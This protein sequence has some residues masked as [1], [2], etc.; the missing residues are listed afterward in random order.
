MAQPPD[1]EP[2]LSRWSKRK[3][4]E[5]RDPKPGTTPDDEALPEDDDSISRE[6]LAALPAIEDLTARTDIRP[7]LRKG[8]PQAM[9][10]AALRKSW[11]LTPAIRDHKDPAVDYA[12]DWNT[13]GGV[14]GDGVGPSVERATEMLREMVAPRRD[15][16]PEKEI[17]CNE[18]HSADTPDADAFSAPQHSATAEPE[19]AQAP[20]PHRAELAKPEQSKIKAKQSDNDAPPPRRRHGGALPD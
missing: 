2:F 11:L 20:V 3:R 6:E 14:P 13:P 9:R 17:E 10:N 15:A 18:N 12:W 19:T 4:V 16:E 7:F 5:A 8:V 1:D